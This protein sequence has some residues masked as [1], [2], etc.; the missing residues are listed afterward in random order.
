MKVEVR[1]HRPGSSRKPKPTARRSK[2]LRFL[3][4]LVSAVLAGLITAATV[5][6]LNW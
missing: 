3:A 6:W 4:D 1:R 5:K 2:V